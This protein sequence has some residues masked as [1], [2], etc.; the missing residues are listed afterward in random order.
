MSLLGIDVGTTGC[1]AIVFRD[2][3]AILGSGYREYPLLHP[4]PT[5]AEL[6]PDDVWEATKESIREAVTRAGSG[7]PVKAIAPS[8]Q[9]EAMTPIDRDGRPLANSIVSFDPRTAPQRDW[10]EQTWG[11]QR[12]FQ[13]TGMPLHT[14]YSL[15]KM[16]WVK[17]N[18]PDVYRTAWK[19]LC[20]GDLTIYRLGGPPAIDY[21]MAGRTM[22]FDLK[23][24]RWSPEILSHADIDPALLPEP[25]PS[26][27]P[28]GHVSASVAE[29]LGLPVVDGHGPLL[30]TGGHDQPCGA[31]GAGITRPG[32]A[33]DATGT[34]ECITPAFDHP[35]LTD[36]ML[37]N[38]YC[39]Y[40][41]VAPG[42]YC[43]IAFSFT[44]GSLL[45]WYR[46]TFG[47]KEAEEARVS[48]LDVYEIILGKAG[49]HPSPLLVLPHFT[50]T[51]TPWFDPHSKGAILGLTLSTTKGEFVKGLVDGVTY[52]M[53]L[54]LDALEGAGVP[55]SELR[56][57]GGGAK[58]SIWMQVK[59]DVFRR[60]V[61]SLDVSEAACLGAAILAGSAC[62]VYGSVQ[63]AAD[64]VVCV[65]DKYEPREDVAALYDEKYRLFRRIYPAL[66]DLLHEM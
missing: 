7:D 48:G 22:A 9:G 50:V 4:Q 34:V 14:M 35:V 55:I 42:L 41:H 19:F 30:V 8:S 45:R 26:G 15:L 38:N 40:H 12:L 24:C 6:D 13:I 47:D 57:I 5:W 44:G 53:R 66:K 37:E 10:W 52:E 58:S 43:T 60:P 23:A 49:S 28:V 33:M 3:G 46:D 27:T 51:G 25:H 32:I 59:A 16:Q 61:Y 56:A 29:E 2:D 11:K 54:N 63:E 39:C 18:Q 17:E 20:Y 21:S 65:K 1:K 62:G 64:C 36:G 31:L